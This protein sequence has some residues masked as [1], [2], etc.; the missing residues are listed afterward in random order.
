MTYSKL[1]TAGLSTA[2]LLGS[3]APALADERGQDDS[4]S[5]VHAPA[6]FPGS[7]FLQGISARVEERRQEHASNTEDRQQK[8][9][10]LQQQRQ[11]KLEDR[12]TNEIDKRIESLT[13]LKERL[14]GVKLIGAD[15]L[16]GIL[17]SIDAEIAKLQGLKTNITS[18]EASTTLK[19][20]VQ[21]VTKS[22][23]IYALVE[24][25]AHIAASASRI[26]AVVTQMTAL[27]DKLQAR[28][29]SAK[30]A[31]T[32]TTAAESAL[33]DLKVKIADAKV[34]ADAAVSET[35]NL[36]ADNGDATV[37]AS[38]NAA[39]KDA[40]HKLVAAEKDLAAA[41][42]DAAKVYAVVKGSGG[43]ATTTPST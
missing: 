4:G 16:A 21:S 29:D 26:S 22:L 6:S 41:R 34:Q 20:D 42:H 28:I 8:Q 9:E 36:Q 37:R 27:A 18:G 13:K 19:A 23:R 5:E 15:V 10:E 31:G 39:L 35:A 12:G 3:A 1:I 11:Q 38:N 43:N 25:Q 14:S 32:D 17:S 2:L 7:S 40:R 30:S 24:P 33:A